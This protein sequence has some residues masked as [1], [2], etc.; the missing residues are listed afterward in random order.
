MESPDRVNTLA[1]IVTLLN[2]QFPSLA[3]QFACLTDLAGAICGAGSNSLL[4]TVFFAVAALKDCGASPDAVIKL[5]QAMAANANT[6]PD[7]SDQSCLETDAV[8]SLDPNDISGPR[9]FGQQRWVAETASLP[10]GVFF[11]NEI[12]ATAPAQDVVVGNTLNPA[13]LNVGSLALGPLAF[14]T[15]AVDPPSLPLTILGSFTQDVDL[16]PT[17]DLIARVTASLNARTGSLTWHFQSIDPSTGKPTTNPLLG[18]LP[19]GE[20]GSVTFTGQ[21]LQTLRTGTQ[22]R[23]Q[24]TVVFDVNPPIS[25]PIWLNTI[26]NAPPTSSVS[27]LAPEQ[28]TS[29]FDVQWSGTDVGSG[30]ANFTIFASDDGRAYAPWLSGTTLTAAVFNGQAGQ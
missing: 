26:D 17:Q 5:E 13:N 14:G 10:Y 8:D 27:A 28:A 18:F 22:V 21:P 1:A 6:A 29:C 16:R 25:T 2:S 30:L 19:P 12:S 11:A 24:A 23:D 9:G 7:S 3:P 20:Q 15:H 4:Q